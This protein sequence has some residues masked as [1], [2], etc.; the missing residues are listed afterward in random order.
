MK[1]SLVGKVSE[2]ENSSS[3]G[4]SLA[5]PPQAGLVSV[6]NI[7]FDTRLLLWRATGEGPAH[8]ASSS[9]PMGRLNRTAA[10]GGVAGRRDRGGLGAAEQ[11]AGLLG[12][13]AFTAFFGSSSSMLTGGTLGGGGL[14]FISGLRLL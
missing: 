3:G 14:L 11:R 12:R 8:G 1:L 7:T 9:C 13:E 4:G 5:T 10:E 2:K 6:Q